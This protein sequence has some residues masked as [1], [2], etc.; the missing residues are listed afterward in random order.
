MKE[1]DNKRVNFFKVV[2]LLDLTS[3]EIADNTKQDRGNVNKYFNNT[4]PPS[5]GFLQKFESFYEIDLNEIDLSKVKKTENCNSDIVFL[6]KGVPYYDNIDLSIL[7]TENN[8]IKP[9]FYINYDH[10][11]DCHAYVQVFGDSMSPMF[12]SGEIVSIKR[13]LNFDVLLWGESY[14]IITNSN[15]NDLKTIKQVYKHEDASKII[16]NST[17]LDY[18]GEIVIDKNDILFMYII[19]GKITRIQI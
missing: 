5:R 3:T 7:S 4:L 6:N 9:N 18:K 12:N 8:N 16:L 2:E 19:K 14:Y 11:N 15:S 1:L 17:N 10:F 13:I